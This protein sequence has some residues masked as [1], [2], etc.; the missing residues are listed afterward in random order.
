MP[1][2]PQAD[3]MLVAPVLV[4]LIIASA[5]VGFGKKNPALAGMKLLHLLVKNRA[6]LDDY[7]VKVIL[8]VVVFKVII[9]LFPAP[10]IVPE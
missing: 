10:L 3:R 2:Y 7:L 9:E 4:Q 5:C 8:P 1:A 6:H